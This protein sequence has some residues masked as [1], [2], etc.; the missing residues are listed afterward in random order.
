MYEKRRM[1]LKWQFCANVM[2]GFYLNSDNSL[3][4]VR[5]FVESQCCIFYIWSYRIPTENP[6]ETTQ[7]SSNSLLQSHFDLALACIQGFTSPRGLPTIT[8]SYTKSFTRCCPAQAIF[9]LWNAW[10]IITCTSSTIWFKCDLSYWILGLILHCSL[11]PA[12]G[13]CC[14]LLELPEGCFH[15]SPNLRAL[16][17]QGWH[18]LISVSPVSCTELGT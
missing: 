4:K 15:I 14:A 12:P 7:L 2:V 16:L 6:S 13:K 9:S 17:G 8:T 11:P 10:L 5:G 18:S 3:D 1:W